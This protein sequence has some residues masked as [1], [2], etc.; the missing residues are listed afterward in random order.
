MKRS[1][2]S[3]ADWRFIQSSIPVT[4]VDV[5]PVRF[6]S[7]SRRVLR[8]VGL[9]LRETP[10]G[11]KWCLIGGR[12]MHRE[13]LCAAVRRQMTEALGRQIRLHIMPDQQPLYVAQYSAGGK[14]PFALDPRQHSVSLTYAVELEGVPI[15]GG[16]AIQFE[17]FEIENLPPARQIGFRQTT[18]VKACLRLLRKC[19]N[20]PLK[21][22]KKNPTSRLCDMVR[23]HQGPTPR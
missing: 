15:P 2:L 12:L 8:E 3:R 22:A 7:G 14:N 5:L 23:A 4:C 21:T 1:W 10:Y 9:I 17:W 13:P 18:V 16:E 19:S 20:T 6:S 11:R